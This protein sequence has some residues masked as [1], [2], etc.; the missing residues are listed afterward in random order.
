[1]AAAEYVPLPAWL[2]EIV[3]VPGLSI[4]IID[5][6]TAQTPGVAEDNETPSPEDADALI[7]GALETPK[8]APVSA[9]KEIV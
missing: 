3:Q 9:S 2:A 8:V 7:N 1:M 4:E 5:P 6:E